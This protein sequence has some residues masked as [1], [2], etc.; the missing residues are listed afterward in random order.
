MLSLPV[1]NARSAAR[2][3]SASHPDQIANGLQRG[4]HRINE[5]QAQRDTNWP[6]IEGDC[7]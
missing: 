2:S 6:I 1:P 5:W 4:D 3:T 7:G